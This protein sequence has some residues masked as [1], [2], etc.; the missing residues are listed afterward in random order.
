MN[1]D[2]NLNKTPRSLLI[3]YVLVLYVVFQFCWW[4][5]LL[6]HLNNQIFDLKASL[7]GLIQKDAGSI[8]QLKSKLSQ[9]QRMIF[10]EGLVFLL[11][12]LL[13]MLQTRKS[14]RRENR[15]ARLQKNF[16]LSVTHELKSPIASVKLYLQTLE[17]RDL[18]RSKQLDLVKKAIQ[19]TNRLDLLVE[20]ILLAAQIDNRVL[21]IQQETINLTEFIENFIH[22]FEEKNEINIEGQREENVQ[23]KADSLALHSILLNITENSLKYGGLSPKIAI[24]LRTQFDQIILRISDEGIGIKEDERERVFEKFFRSGNE[25]TR[26]SK[27]TGLGLYIVKYL[28]NQQ[29]GSISVLHNTPKGSIFELRFKIVESND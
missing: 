17:K 8:I 16:L 3:F 26:Q 14:F 7:T 12:L 25:E 23:I 5:Y 2:L 15:V 19:D 4:Y 13:G 28:V 9:K 29:K 20:N 18:D 6:F 27:G 11:L 22:E 10:G 24:E 21:K 1:V